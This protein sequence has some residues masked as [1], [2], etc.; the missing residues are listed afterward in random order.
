[1]FPVCWDGSAGAQTGG[2]FLK[3]SVASTDPMLHTAL[4]LIYNI[5]VMHG[6][7]VITSNT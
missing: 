1:M 7:Y 3:A 2:L 6:E 4:N 5:K